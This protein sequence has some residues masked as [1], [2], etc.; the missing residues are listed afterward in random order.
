[1]CQPMPSYEELL[2]VFREEIDAHLHWQDAQSFYGLLTT[3]TGWR[4]PARAV[5][6]ELEKLRTS[7]LLT[8]P[9]FEEALTTFYSLYAS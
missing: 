7:G 5:F 1:M 6:D 4:M 8:S 9:R 2:R 3:E